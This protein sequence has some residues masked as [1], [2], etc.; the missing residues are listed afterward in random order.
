MS[1]KGSNMKN[2][3]VC[4]VDLKRYSGIWF[5]IAKL[6]A[7]GQNGLSNVTATYI[8]QKSGKIRVINKGY[9]NGKKKGIKG[10]AWPRD[11]RCRGALYVRFFWPFK[12]EYNVL[13]IAPDYRYAV[14]AGDDK[15]SLWILSR[16]PQMSMHDLEEILYFVKAEG[17]NVRKLMHTPQDGKRRS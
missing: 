5:E 8:P 2:V 16:T 15:D 11:K 17:F 10:Y 6:P 13:S 7:R 1:I 4:N 14:V 12:S 9:R 3:P